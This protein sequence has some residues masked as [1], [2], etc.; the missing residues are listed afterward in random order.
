MTSNHNTRLA[1]LTSVLLCACATPTVVQSVKPGDYGLTCAQLQNEFADAERFRAEA[2][3]E[4]SVT[5]GN[6]VRALLFWPAILGTASNAN[7]AIAAADSRKVNLANI[8][9]Q[10]NCAIPITPVIVNNPNSNPSQ[11]TAPNQQS[12]D[13]Q[14]TEL[15]RLFDANLITK[16]V[17]AERQK[18]ILERSAK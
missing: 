6:V 18:L 16:E 10:K 11:V 14:L 1:A 17:Y 3:A 13:A 8:M 12:T 2:D 15:K 4:K 9:N 7:E 5:G